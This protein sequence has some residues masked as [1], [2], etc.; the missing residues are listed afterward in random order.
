MLERSDAV[1]PTNDNDFFLPRLA[2]S[3]RSESK[4]K[5]RKAREFDVNGDNDH[6]DGVLWATKDK[7]RHVPFDALRLLRIYDRVYD[8]TSKAVPGYRISESCAV[9]P[10]TVF[11]LGVCYM[12]AFLVFGC[13]CDPAGSLC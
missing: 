3:E 7:P 11:V 5:A 1:K 6:I 2:L 8:R 9:K 12:R 10:P 13:C 4:V